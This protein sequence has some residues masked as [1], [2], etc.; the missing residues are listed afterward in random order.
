MLLPIRHVRAQTVEVEIGE[1]AVGS[2]EIAKGALQNRASSYIVA[3]RLMMKRDRQL[4]QPLHV[5]T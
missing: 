2:M 3:G 1:G 5:Q 4:N